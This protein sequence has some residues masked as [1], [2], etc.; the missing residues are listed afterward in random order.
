MTMGMMRGIFGMNGD[1]KFGCMDKVVGYGFTGLS[2]KR[3]FRGAAAESFAHRAHGNCRT[4]W[5]GGEDEDDIFTRVGG[6]VKLI[7]AG[8]DE[9]ALRDMDEFHRWEAL[10]DAGLNPEEFDY[11]D[12]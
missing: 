3:K 7:L 10:A 9:E 12:M 5:I 6:T 1:G 8:L 4:A 2:R 11:L